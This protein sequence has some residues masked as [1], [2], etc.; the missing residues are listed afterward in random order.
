MNPVFSVMSTKENVPVDLQS[1]RMVLVRYF[2][3]RFS[4]V[5]GGRQTAAIDNAPLVDL[6]DIR[7][8]F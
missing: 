8:S 6:C 1:F 4:H 7:N 3:R 5:L 2:T